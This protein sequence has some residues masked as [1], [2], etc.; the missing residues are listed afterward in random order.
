MAL[1]KFLIQLLDYGV[2]RQHFTL[3]VFGHDDVKFLPYSIIKVSV[4]KL[5]QTALGALKPYSSRPAIYQS[6]H[7]ATCT[8]IV[9]TIQG[10]L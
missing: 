4:C 8:I 3:S 5:V 2:C 9:L 10:V 7:A 1:E 6:N